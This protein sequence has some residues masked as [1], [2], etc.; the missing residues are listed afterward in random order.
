MAAD[1]FYRMRDRFNVRHELI[2]SINDRFSFVLDGDG[3][4]NQDELRCYLPEE[5]LE[6]ILNREEHWNNA[7]IGCKIE[8]DRRP[9]VYLPDVHMLLSFFHLPRP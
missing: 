6:R 8:F 3:G 4:D 2:V 7:E 9:N 5:L 1:N